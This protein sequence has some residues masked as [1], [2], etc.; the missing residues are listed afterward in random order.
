MSDRCVLDP[1]LFEQFIDAEHLLYFACKVYM[2]DSSY[3][4]IFM[5]TI[6]GLLSE[7]IENVENYP[8]GRVRELISKLDYWDSV[9]P[10]QSGKG[11]KSAW[12]FFSSWL[13]KIF[14]VVP[15]DIFNRTFNELLGELNR[16]KKSKIKYRS[17]SY[18]NEYVDGYVFCPQCF[19]AFI[20]GADYFPLTRCPYCELILENPQYT[21]EAT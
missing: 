3:H 14:Q 12:S 15:S 10:L 4:N 13:D 5:S 20:P 18:P 17:I 19:E 1:V 2:E 9:D 16:P 21:E 8:Q 11:H 6:N 7:S